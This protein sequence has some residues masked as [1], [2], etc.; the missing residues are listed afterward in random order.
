VHRPGDQLLAG[1]RFARDQD[2][3]SRGRHA[4]DES[5]DLLH[6]RRLPHDRGETS[7]RGGAA[8]LIELATHRQI[9]E[10]AV[11]DS[12]D[13][14]EAERLAHVVARAEPHGLH[15]RLDDRAV[16]HDDDLG[17]GVHGRERGEHIE[18][19]DL[20]EVEGEEHHV[21]RP[22]SQDV[23]GDL[24]VLGA[25]HLMA[26]F[27]ERV[28]ETLCLGRVRLRHEDHPGA[29]RWGGGFRRRSPHGQCRCHRATP[30]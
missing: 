28:R 6:G 18:P 26:G 22:G 2:G 3:R 27:A 20:G 14:V 15:R 30:L 11:D 24:A 8:Q 4:L 21:H 19:A 1:A 5:E 10:L 9:G 29:R 16:A 7:V 23:E 17:V 13:L 25:P 12:E